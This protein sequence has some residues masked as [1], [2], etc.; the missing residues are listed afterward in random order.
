MGECGYNFTPDTYRIGD[1]VGSRTSLDALEK[2]K[3]FLFLTEIEIYTL[4]SPDH[5]IVTITVP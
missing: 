4:N 3:N 5:G 2:E 1:W